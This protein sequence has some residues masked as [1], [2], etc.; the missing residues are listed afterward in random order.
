[1]SA[2]SSSGLRIQILLLAASI[3][4]PTAFAVDGEFEQ[5]IPAGDIV[6]L[7]VR[8]GSG[9]I[10]VRS[11]TG[12]EAVVRGEIHVNKRFFFGRP[13]NSSEIVQGLEDNPPIAMNGGQL[14]VGHITDRSV[15]NKVSISYDITVPAGTSVVA[16]TGSGSIS[17]VD[18]SATVEA[19]AG[20]GSIR[21]TNIGAPVHA[22]TGSGS[23]KA[24]GVAGSFKGSS[25]SGKITVTQTSP[26]DV[27][28]ST[29]SGSSEILGIVGALRADA[30]S[31]SI[32]VEGQM[33][34]AWH[35]D[36]GSGT[37]RVS[38]PDD[39]AFDFDASAS[40]GGIKIDH[41]LT[42]SGEISKRRIRGSV[43]GGGPTLN[44][45]TGSGGIQVR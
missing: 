29:G 9:S 6:S 11:G 38:L 17:V 18:M 14:R 20:S 19:E 36:T 37:V 41:P 34:G 7:D 22:H 35:L 25:G 33:T 31:G 21:L 43:R 39:A 27:E 1:M 3:W 5:R 44:I 13:K 24:D 16:D 4:A 42:V 23:I 26:G 2:L 32:T 28:V 12:N 45:D 30:G 15:R 8:T 40:S 10:K